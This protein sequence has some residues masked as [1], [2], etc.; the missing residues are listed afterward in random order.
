MR[1]TLLIVVLI[2]NA[3]ISL[4][5]DTRTI[6][7]EYIKDR[8]VF[9]ICNC[10]NNINSKETNK[11]SLQIFKCFKKDNTLQGLG[12]REDYSDGY[13]NEFERER[14]SILYDESRNNI[15]TSIFN[16]LTNECPKL[17]ELVTKMYLNTDHVNSSSAH[18]VA[19]PTNLNEKTLKKINR[20][21]KLSNWDGITVALE[22]EITEVKYV[23]A[24]SNF[25]KVKI[26]DQSIWVSSNIRNPF[27]VV[28]NKVRIIGYLVSI[29]ADSTE[30]I[31]H[32]NNHHI[33]VTGILDI[34]TRKLAYNTYS[35]S[36]I[37][38]WGEGNITIIKN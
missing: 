4:G 38:S 16:R 20:K 10:I 2:F 6:E 28:G 36:Q 21:K 14:Q 24:K 7:T 11:I 18:G 33:L 17:K 26:G 34:K 1:N 9:E 8:G 19:Y 30:F 37:T 22:S 31:P 12:R 23:D 25:F 35:E 13:K 27:E 3:F 29:N 5:Q 15:N 32:H